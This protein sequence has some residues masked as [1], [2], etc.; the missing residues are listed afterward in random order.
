M[1]DVLSLSDED[2][3]KAVARFT[4]L[5]VPAR[6]GYNIVPSELMVVGPD[7]DKGKQDE[8]L[9]KALARAKR[10]GLQMVV[11]NNGPSRKVPDGFDMT[12]AWKQLVD[13]GRRAAAEAKKAGLTVL[14]Q[15][16]RKE[17]TNLVVDVPSALKLVQDVGRPNF[18]LL[19][20]YSFMV[21]GNED[22]AVLA[23]ARGHLKHVWISN[24]NGRVYPMN[25][26][27]AD[28]AA[29][30]AALKKIGYGGGVS[31]HARTDNFFAD[32]PSAIAFLR[33]QAAG[34]K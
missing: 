2:F 27:E 29:F 14:V 21:L 17:E 23:Q 5:G 18:Q 4:A 13:F 12:R 22:P 32:A 11:L 7:A 20:D 15:P 34:L 6:V 30:F 8:H 28:Y 24:P 3:E 33:G 10:L 31:V 26:S 9:K 1:Q 25:A 19:V 16:L